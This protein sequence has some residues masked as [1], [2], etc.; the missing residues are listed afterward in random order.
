MKHFLINI[1]VVVLFRQKMLYVAFSLYTNGTV[2]TQAQKQNVNF[3]ILHVHM[4]LCQ[5]KNAQG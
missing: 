1:L 2:H 5:I 3:N 4:H